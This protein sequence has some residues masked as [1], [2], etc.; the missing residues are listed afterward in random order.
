[1]GKTCSQHLPHR[2]ASQVVRPRAPAVDPAGGL[3]IL[4][5]MGFTVSLAAAGN[6]PGTSSSRRIAP[7]IRIGSLPHA[8]TTV[9]FTQPSSPTACEVI[10]QRDGE[11]VYG[12]EVPLRFEVAPRPVLYRS[13][14]EGEARSTWLAMSRL[15]A[16]LDNKTQSSKGEQLVLAAWP[17]SLGLVTPIQ[18]RSRCRANSRA[19]LHED[20]AAKNANDLRKLLSAYDKLSDDPFSTVK[21]TRIASSF[22]LGAFDPANTHKKTRAPSNRQGDHLPGWILGICALERCLDALGQHDDTI[23]TTAWAIAKIPRQVRR[24]HRD[25]ILADALPRAKKLALA[26]FASEDDRIDAESRGDLRVAPYATRIC[27]R[28]IET[29]AQS[30]YRGTDPGRERDRKAREQCRANEADRASE[31]PSPNDAQGD[32]TTEE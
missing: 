7:T 19:Q 25:D 6:Q 18:F 2:Q 21:G 9:R 29:I 5:H 22:V 28:L 10:L 16:R 26:G 20:L 11:L 8:R 4:R 27:R 24:D 30:E 17:Y 32:E 23:A 31:R 13:S 1:M 12:E 14:R 15:E 3:A